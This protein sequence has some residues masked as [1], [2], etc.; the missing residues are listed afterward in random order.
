M[1]IT[2]SKTTTSQDSLIRVFHKISIFPRNFLQGLFLFRDFKASRHCRSRPPRPATGATG[3]R[4]LK[5]RRIP[6]LVPAKWVQ[7]YPGRRMYV[8]S[9]GGKPPRCL[10]VAE[11]PAAGCHGHKSEPTGRHASVGRPVRVR[12]DLET[13]DTSAEAQTSSP[14]HFGQQLECTLRLVPLPAYADGRAVWDQ[15]GF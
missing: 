11:A 7:P 9:G 2:T 12:P 10:L 13:S 4:I 1:T 8:L 3:P 14:L 6:Y 5:R 15:V